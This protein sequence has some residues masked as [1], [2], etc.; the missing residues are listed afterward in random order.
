MEFSTGG[1]SVTMWRGTVMVTTLRKLGS[2]ISANSVHKHSF[3]D[4]HVACVAQFPGFVMT[5]IWRRSCRNQWKNRACLI[6]HWK[7]FLRVAICETASRWINDVAFTSPSWKKYMPMIGW[8]TSATTMSWEQGLPRKMKLAFW[9]PKV[10]RRCPFA[11]DKLWSVGLGERFF[12]EVGGKTDTAEPQ[13]TKKPS[14]KRSNLLRW[15]GESDTMPITDR[16]WRFPLVNSCPSLGQVD[17][18]GKEDQHNIS[19]DPWSSDDT[20]RVDFR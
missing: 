2:V 11:A 4:I 9:R 18:V 20:S 1:P 6:V 14:T 5:G 10:R 7:L 8:T 15:T 13:S 17:V 16:P 19:L 3:K 12:F